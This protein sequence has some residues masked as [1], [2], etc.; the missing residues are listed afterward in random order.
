MPQI[1]KPPLNMQCAQLFRVNKR[2]IITVG[3][4]GNMDHEW[5]HEQE[6]PKMGSFD[7]I[8]SQAMLEHLLNPY[9][10]VA[11][12]SGVLKPG[13]TLILHTHIP[14]FGYHLITEERCVTQKACDISRIE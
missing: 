14:G 1:G 6:P 12:L 5:N 13:T 3:V 9:K 8:I 4:G 7:I 10:H 2:Q 11:D